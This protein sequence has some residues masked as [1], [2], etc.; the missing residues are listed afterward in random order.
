MD[1][2]A[3]PRDCFDYIGQYLTI[4]D[5]ISLYRAFPKRP[6]PHNTRLKAIGIRNVIHRTP[7]CEKLIARYDLVER[8]NCADP[9]HAAVDVLTS[10]DSLMKLVSFLN[11]SLSIS[12][13]FVFDSVIVVKNMQ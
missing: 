11:I 13:P 5:R 8:W 9:E 3:L 6:R 7:I 1:I 10:S 2:T 12:N 4:D